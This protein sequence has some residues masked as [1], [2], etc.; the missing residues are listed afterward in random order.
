MFGA[1]I[2]LLAGSLIVA[3]CCKGNFEFASKL[4]C[5]KMVVGDCI[6]LW[7]DEGNDKLT[8]GPGTVTF[9]EGIL[10]DEISWFKF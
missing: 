2:G 4:A 7:F 10:L 1:S 5:L 8:R 3:F 6:V 9:F